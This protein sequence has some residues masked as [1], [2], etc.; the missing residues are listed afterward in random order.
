VV[1][2]VYGRARWLIVPATLLVPLVLVT[3]SIRLPLDGRFGD[4]SV[5]PNEPGQLRGAYTNTAGNLF[6]D[7]NRFRGRDEVVDLPLRL[8]TVVGSATVVLPYDASYEVRGYAGLG[9]VS[10][11]PI[12]REGVEVSA[13][14]RFVSPFEGGP[15]FVLDLEAG[16]GN[17]AVYLSVPNRRIDR[18]IREALE[19]RFTET[20]A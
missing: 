17:V 1:G 11:G 9:S 20:V 19:R 13:A 16:V 3:S 5:R 12:D 6:V 2:S 14:A 10:V 4:L 15:S 18:Q 8:T 7:L